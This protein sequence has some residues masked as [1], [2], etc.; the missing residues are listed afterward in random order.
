MMGW[1]DDAERLATLMPVVERL[2]RLHLSLILGRA[3]AHIRAG[4]PLEVHVWWGG[5]QR[6]SDLMLLLAYLL[7]RNPEW[8]D[9]RIRVLSVASNELMRRE[10]ERTLARLMPE[11]RIDADVEVRMRT[12]DESVRDV[13]HEVSG[14]ADLVLLGL[15]TPEAGGEREYAERITDLA[16]GLRGFFFVKNGSL[17]VG[18]LVSPAETRPETPVAD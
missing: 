17:F 2:E 3:P 8:R 10:T 12:G 14:Q 13:I 9:T 7:S 1:P 4:Q 11:I 6:N 5:L 15:A 18:D 16:A